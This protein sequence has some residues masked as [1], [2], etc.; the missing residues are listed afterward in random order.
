MVPILGYLSRRRNNHCASFIDMDPFFV[1]Y[2]LPLVGAIPGVGL[3][4]VVEANER[5]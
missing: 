3:L 4:L 2:H 5:K 1:L